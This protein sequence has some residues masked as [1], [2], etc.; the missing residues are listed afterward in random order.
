MIKIY[1]VTDRS[2]PFIVKDISV[3]GDYYESRM[4][5]DYVYVVVNERASPAHFAWDTELPAISLVPPVEEQIILHPH[6]R[7]SITTLGQ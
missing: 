2:K 1:D 6:A 3:S 7:A 5:G 4:I